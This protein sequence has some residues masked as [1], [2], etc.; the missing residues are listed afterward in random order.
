[1]ASAPVSVFGDTGA[2]RVCML[3]PAAT[4]STAL[5]FLGRGEDR[6]RGGDASCDATEISG[7]VLTRSGCARKTAPGVVALSHP[8]SNATLS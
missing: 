1:M 5:Y 6:I 3:S 8:Y 2:T 7:R 4:T